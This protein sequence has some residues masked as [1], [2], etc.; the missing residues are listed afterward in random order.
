MA[1]TMEALYGTALRKEEWWK[2]QMRQF[3]G[4]PRDLD[5]TLETSIDAGPNDDAVMGYCPE[6]VDRRT[7]F[8]L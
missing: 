4:L 6:E 2:R 3:L 8:C 7:H 5:P 1:L